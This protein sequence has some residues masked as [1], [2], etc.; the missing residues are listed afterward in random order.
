VRSVSWSIIAQLILYSAHILTA[1]VLLVID[2]RDLQY[3]E[4]WF[5]GKK[6]KRMYKYT[7][8]DRDPGLFAGDVLRVP[9]D[10]VSDGVTLA[11]YAESSVTPVLGK[12]LGMSPSMRNGVEGLVLFGI[13]PIIRNKAPG[14]RP[15]GPIGSCVKSIVS[16]FSVSHLD[17]TYSRAH[18]HIQVD[19]IE[20]IN[21]AGGYQLVDMSQASETPCSPPC[22]GFVPGRSCR[23]LI[24]LLKSINDTQACWLLALHGKPNS[25][26]WACQCCEIGASSKA[27]TGYPAPTFPDTIRYIYIYV[28]VTLS[29]LFLRRLVMLCIISFVIVSL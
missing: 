5:D 8:E 9:M 14:Y 24:D 1:S 15:G 23:V 13:C 18:V 7:E 16:M 17:N 20:N 4:D 25:L 29:L 19:T 2:P 6:A 28:C 11:N 21:R 22:S 12:T 3:I 10:L 26:L 27:V